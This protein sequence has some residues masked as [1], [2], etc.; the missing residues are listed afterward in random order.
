VLTRLNWEARKLLAAQ[1]D[2]SKLAALVEPVVETLLFADEAKL[3]GPISGTSGF[4]A[5]FESRGPFD[6]DGRS[7]RQFDLTRRLF[8][9]PLSYVIY[10]QAFDRLPPQAK[11]Q[12]FRRLWEVLSGADQSKQ[13]DRLSANDRKAI[14]EILLETKQDFAAWSAARPANSGQ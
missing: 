2:A 7:L 3:T 6:K 14:L 4:R 8:K 9:Y 12:A 1:P 5:D 10:S 13:F 11:E